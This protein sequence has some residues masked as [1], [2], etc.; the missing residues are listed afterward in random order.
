M[1][2]DLL[3]AS[4]SPVTLNRANLLDH[5]AYS[6][7]ESSAFL[8]SS[9]ERAPRTVPSSDSYGEFRKTLTKGM[10]RVEQ[11]FSNFLVLGP[12]LL[13]KSTYDPK[14]LLLYDWYLLLLT[15]LEINTKTLLILN[16][17]FILK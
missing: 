3:R 6:Q 9:G 4:V 15:I 14:E 16:Y 1:T 10:E 11:R 2:V 7:L 13:L 8:H 17:E 12:I 5:R